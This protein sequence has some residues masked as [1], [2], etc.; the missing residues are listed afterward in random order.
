MMLLAIHSPQ[1]ELGY[2]CLAAMIF[3]VLAAMLHASSPLLAKSKLVSLSW[4]LMAGGC[5]CALLA[6]VWHGTESGA[7][8]AGYAPLKSMYEVM[9]LM[10]WMIAPLAALFRWGLRLRGLW[11]DALLGAVLAFPTVF[12][13]QSEPQQVV[14]ALQ[15]HL[16]IP[17]VIAYLIGYLI[18]FRSAIA[19]GEVVILGVRPPRT[20]G[21]RSAQEASRA[22]LRLGFPLITLGMLLGSLWAQVRGDW[23]GWDAKEQWSLVTWLILAAALHVPYTTLGKKFRRV[24]AI[25]VLLGAFTMI[26]TLFWSQIASALTEAGW[27]AKQD[28]YHVYS[29]K[30]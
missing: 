17:H 29:T 22:L 28:S 11:I 15:T 12:I 16:F 25:F 27:L 24:M 5:V 14:P 7:F 21:M 8:A 9:L 4:G 6:W 18:V 20:L 30:K 3:Y 1:G 2:L 23:W 13:F 19:A 26:V 10:T